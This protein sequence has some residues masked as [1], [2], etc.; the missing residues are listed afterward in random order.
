MRGERSRGYCTRDSWNRERRVIVKAERLP[1]KSVGKT[2]GGPE[3]VA[4]GQRA[5]IGEAR[6]Y[7]RF[8]V[9]SLREPDA[10]T[11][12][13]AMYCDRGE[14]ENW[15]KEQKHDLFLDRCSS[16]LWN[17]NALR[18]R[19]DRTAPCHLLHDEAPA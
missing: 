10:Q 6:Y 8:V 2:D 16:S 19:L 5:V 12:Y 15:I 13:E 14:A 18:L 17:V 11:V 7:S 3:D 9:T 1:G 4:E